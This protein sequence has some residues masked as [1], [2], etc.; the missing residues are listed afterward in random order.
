MGRKE[1]FQLMEMSLWRCHNVLNVLS[2]YLMF[3]FSVLQ[4]LLIKLY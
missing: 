3:E 1:D 4:N 2:E